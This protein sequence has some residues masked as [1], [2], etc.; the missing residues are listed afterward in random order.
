VRGTVIGFVVLTAIGIVTYFFAASIVAFFIPEDPAVIAEGAGF[1]RVMCLAWGC[2]G[3]QLGIVSAFRASG[4]MLIAMVI[5][6]VSQWTIQ[7]PLAYVLSKHT[8]LLAEGIWW[9]FPATNVAVAIIALC[10]F[11][12]GS[13]KKTRLTEEAKEAALVTQETIIEDGIR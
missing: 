12:R 4:N 7:F 13:W 1:I 5:A 6:L 10:W 11:S 8:T 3:V 2:I 9:S